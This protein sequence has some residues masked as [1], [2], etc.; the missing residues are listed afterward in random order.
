MSRMLGC[1][2]AVVVGVNCIYIGANKMA[3]D[4]GS[5]NIRVGILRLLIVG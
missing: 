1:F 5:N 3:A 2:N 4:R